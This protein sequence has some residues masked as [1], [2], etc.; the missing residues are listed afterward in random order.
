MLERFNLLPL[1]EPVKSKECVS[2]SISKQANL[3]MHQHLV[4]P[5]IA[6]ACIMLGSLTAAPFPSIIWTSF[7]SPTENS[8]Y[9]LQYRIL[10]WLSS[11]LLDSECLEGCGHAASSVALPH[12]HPGSQYQYLVLPPAI[13]I[14]C[15]WLKLKNLF[16]PKWKKHPFAWKLDV[17]AGG[18]S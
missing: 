9:F 11:F 5:G 16:F 13:M 7:L 8:V 4:W 2:V 14:K 15:P 10:A 3:H 17:A 1:N 12:W 6:W 18:L